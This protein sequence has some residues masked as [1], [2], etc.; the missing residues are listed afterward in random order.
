MLDREFDRAAGISSK[1]VTWSPAAPR[2]RTSSSS[3]RCGGVEPTSAV[4]VSARLREQLQRR[5]P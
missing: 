5:P 4:A 2:R 3:A 1:L